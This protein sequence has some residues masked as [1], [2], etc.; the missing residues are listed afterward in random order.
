[1]SASALRRVLF[2]SPH[3]PPDGTAG[4]HRARLLAPRLPEHG[5]EPTVLTVDPSGYE[6][7]LDPALAD[8]VPRDVRVVRAHAWPAALTRRLGIGDLGLRAIAPLARQARAV[9]SREPFDAM[10]ITIYPTYPALLAPML[11]RRFHLPFV[12]DYQDP[13][14]GEWGC[15]VGGGVGG[16]P[17]MKSRASRWLATRLEPIA[18]RAADAV[19][20]VSA[21]TYEQAFARYHIRRTATVAELPIGWE[22]RDAAVAG[23]VGRSNAI[24]PKGD[25]LVHMVYVGTLLPTGLDTLRALCAG[26]S[27]WRARD[28]PS[29]ERLRIHFVGTSN[30]RAGGTPR[31]LPIAREHG[32]ADLVSEHPDRIDY[33]D[34]LATLRDAHAVLLMGSREPHYTPSKLYPAMCSGRPMLAIYHEAS[35]AT[36]LLRRFG[37]PP[38]VRLV[39]FDDERPAASAVDAVAT[40]LQELVR[41]PCY[42]P[43]EVDRRVLE[44]VSAPVL[45][46]R[47]AAILDAVAR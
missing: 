36:P 45:A 22:P 2:V 40:Q 23:R 27:A 47:L 42:T 1:V 34:A 17:D 11:K 39:T 19:T 8:S 13:W 28:A 3:F 4:A 30:Q 26:W 14:V 37:R 7:P 5:W 21:A 41:R 43:D 20:A 15:S 12:L 18:L 44:S 29:A 25:G 10:V 38:A 31:A 24:V 16:A 6:G 33:F 35:T 9:L 32:M 46:G